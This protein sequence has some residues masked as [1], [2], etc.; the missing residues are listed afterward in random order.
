MA[1]FS[2][3][4]YQITF[5][6][7]IG[8]AIGITL[9][10]NNGENTLIFQIFSFPIWMSLLFHVS[11]LMGDFRPFFVFIF[12]VLACL[13]I[14]SFIKEFIKTKFLQHTQHWE[15][16][17]E[18]C[19]DLN[20]SSD[21]S[22]NNSLNDQSFQGSEKNDLP[23]S[24]KNISPI[25]KRTNTLKTS[26]VSQLINFIKTN[27]NQEFKFN[28][29]HSLN[30]SKHSHHS[31]LRENSSN[32]YFYLLFW[33]FLIVNVRYDL[34]FVIT[35]IVIIWKLV[36]NLIIYL[37]KFV[38]DIK[39]FQSY[40]KVVTQWLDVRSAAIMPTP[41]TFLIKIFVKGDHRMNQWLQKS[42]DNIISGLM[43][44]FLLF[45]IIMAFLVL[46]TQVNYIKL[47]ILK[48]YKNKPF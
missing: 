18:S 43:I 29:T 14:F 12:C 38:T 25:L 44:M 42:M 24:I 16:L 5:A 48:L 31:K 6:L 19:C 47:L 21:N 34:Y 28:E 17:D 39:K 37:Y 7:L 40:S 33:L 11:K 22:F 26:K 45:F 2:D 10:W 27:F 30:K 20:N 46:A 41:F 32:K 3:N 13:G 35:V 9:Y 8:Y 23:S 15:L 1:H 4:S 36:K